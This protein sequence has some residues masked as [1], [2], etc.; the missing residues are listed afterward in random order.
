MY[1]LNQ[2][3]ISRSCDDQGVDLCPISQSC[4]PPLKHFLYFQN[5]AVYLF[6]VGINSC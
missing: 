1:V 3:D 4:Q 5:N 2:T 6:V